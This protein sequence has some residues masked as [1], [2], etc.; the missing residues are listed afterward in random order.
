MMVEYNKPKQDIVAL[1]KIAT[2]QKLK[3]LRARDNNRVHVKQ[4]LGGDAQ[5]LGVQDYQPHSEHKGECP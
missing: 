1:H 2:T 5:G 4:H 3:L